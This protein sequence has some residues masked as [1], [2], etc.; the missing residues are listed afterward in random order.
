MKKIQD[1]NGVW[2]R[3]PAITGA[4]LCQ[5]SYEANDVKGRSIVG[6]YVSVKEMSVHDMWNK[7]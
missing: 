6:S 3:D 7:S 4:M 1:F 2:S 5:M